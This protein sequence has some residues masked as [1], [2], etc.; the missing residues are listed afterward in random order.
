ML[1]D[2]AENINYFLFVENVMLLTDEPHGAG[3]KYLQIL[4]PF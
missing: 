4:S 3:T 1:V 2:R